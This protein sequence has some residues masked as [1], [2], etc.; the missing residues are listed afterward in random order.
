MKYF[1]DSLEPDDQ[2]ERVYKIITPQG[3]T[4]K[5]LLWDIILHVVNHGTHNRSGVAMV[6][7]KLGHSPSEIEIL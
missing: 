6:L 5:R 4:I 1:V 3:E 7:T 2:L